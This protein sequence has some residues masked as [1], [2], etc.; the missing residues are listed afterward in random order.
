M[1]KTFVCP[2]CGKHRPESQR[3]P[4]ARLRRPLI[5]RM[6]QDVPTW[7]SVATC[8][9]DVQKYR[10]LLLRE[11]LERERGGVGSLEQAV[12][13]RLEQNQLVAENVEL[14]QRSA[15]GA[16]LADR[17]AAFGGSWPFL[18]LFFAVLFGWMGLNAALLSR[19]FD[20]FP[21]ILLNLVLSCLAAIQA[22]V[23]MMSQNRQAAKD[24]RQADHDYQVN[25]KAELEVQLLHEK[26]DHLILEEWHRL[27]EIQALQSEMLEDLVAR[28]APGGGER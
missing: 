9:S 27:I 2:T 5:D 21:F 23:I 3:V 18:S 13:E 25:L 4:A 24:R 7:N 1:H 8:R 11:T 16:R 20:P 14:T 6:L 15:L 10:V 28:G 12:L 26:L 17:V 22:P 19:P